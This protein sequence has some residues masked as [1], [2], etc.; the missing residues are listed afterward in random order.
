[1]NPAEVVVSEIEAERGPVVLPISDTT[2]STAKSAMS[3]GRTTP[4]S[5]IDRYS[6][7]SV[8]GHY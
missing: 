2:D 3:L 8:R 1:M 5:E 7:V 4:W 6:L